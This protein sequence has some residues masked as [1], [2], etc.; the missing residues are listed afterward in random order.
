MGCYLKAE[1]KSAGVF[2]RQGMIFKFF[3]ERSPKNLSN[4]FEVEEKNFYFKGL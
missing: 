3:E 2:L 4:D 1:D